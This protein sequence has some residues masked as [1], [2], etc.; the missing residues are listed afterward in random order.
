MSL[1]CQ[2]LGACTAQMLFQTAEY[3]IFLALAFVGF[4]ALA[5]LKVARVIFLL[6]ASYIFYAASNPWFLTLIFASTVT[7]FV[8]GKQMKKADVPGGEKRRKAWLIVSLTMNLG[9]L[10]VFKYAN[11]FYSSAVEVANVFGAE[12]LFERL[13]IM[14]PAG[15]SFYT[16]Q[17]MSYSID[18]YRRRMEPESNF[19]R[20]ALFVGY[21]PQLI[22]GPI[23][24][25]V[26][27]VPQLSQTP[28]LTRKQV[29]RAL[30]LIGIG[31]FKKVLFADTLGLNLVDPVFNSPE[32]YTAFEALIALYAY[33]MQVYLDFSAYSDIA[34]G[35]ALL[36]GF[37]LPDNFDRPYMAVS[38]Q[39][40]WRRWHK[41][42]G[43]WLRDYL[44]Y[45][46]G[47]SRHGSLRTYYNLFI[48]F[49]LIG[50]WHGADW[51][52]VVYGCLHA[53]AMCLNRWWRVDVHKRQVIV[54]S[55][56]GLIWRVALTLH[57][58]VLCRILFRCQDFAEVG[59]FN[60]TLLLGAPEGSAWYDIQS[61][62]WLLGLL[63]V[64]FVVHWTPRKWMY[65]IR[66]RLEALPLP[67]Q[68]LLFA[69]VVFGVMANMEIAV[70]FIYFRF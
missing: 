42:L 70:P 30:Y 18:V 44:Y 34:I 13:A 33:T 23:V 10:G 50:L 3:G 47:G 66:D 68:A 20:F 67:G 35:S 31:L 55:R 39:D 19:L 40:F 37:K 43:S 11:F 60:D 17:T 61:E 65:A 62:P 21:F 41:T 36:F 9:L 5:R 6:V 7:D 54:P 69:T 32:Q 22:A 52:F 1:L 58:V 49:V 51:T 53:L 28:I 4:W 45:P 8:A 27:F 29:S 57:F 25:A 15:I 26:D 38:I 2:R 16:F 59:A 63:L 24:R 12:L 48:T 56:W 46:L 64:C 14:L